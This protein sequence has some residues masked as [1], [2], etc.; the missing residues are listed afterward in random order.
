[1]R[2]PTQPTPGEWTAKRFFDRKVYVVT[3]PDSKPF[4]GQVIVSPTTCP[5]YE[6]NAPIL[7]AAKELLAACEIALKAIDEAYKATGYIKVAVTSKER[8]AIT[9]AIM[10]AKRTV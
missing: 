7:A 2:K 4:V 10:K 3:D 6:A 5:E 8:E 9:A 1:M